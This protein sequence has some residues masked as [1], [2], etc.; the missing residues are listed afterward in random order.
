MTLFAKLI[1][2]LNSRRAFLVFTAIA[3]LCAAPRLSASDQ[4]QDRSVIGKWKLTSVLDLAEVSALDDKEARQLV[5]KVL[6]IRRDKVQ[7]GSRVCSP[8]G[9]QA[10]RVEPMMDLREK[11]HASATKLHLPNPVTVVELSCAY[12]YVKSRTRIVLAWDGAF[13]E[14]VR[15]AP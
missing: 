1:S 2:S 14:A 13:F 8:S 10:E 3:A 12:V 9:F 5:G 15:M 7:L 4:H 6:N 11:A